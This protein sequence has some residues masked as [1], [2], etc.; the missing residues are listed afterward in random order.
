VQVDEREGELG[1]AAGRGSGLLEGSAA[2][3]RAP[4]AAE[5]SRGRT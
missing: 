3:R 1:H 5:R 2:S 4:R